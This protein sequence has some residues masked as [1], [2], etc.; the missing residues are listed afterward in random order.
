MGMD[1]AM[2]TM[3]APIDL[4]NLSK[5][6][7]QLNLGYLGISVAILGVLGGVFVYFNIRP[8]QEKLIDQEKAIED[9]K[10]EARELLDKS[11]SQSEKVVEDFKVS[12]EKYVDSILNREH[13]NISLEITKAISETEKGLLEKID[14]VSENKDIKLREIIVSEAVNELGALEK[15]LTAM[16][17]SLEG[18]LGKKTADLDQKI[19]RAKS[20]ISEIQRD[21]KEL[22]VYKF[23][24]EGQMGAIIYSIQLLKQD[25]EDNNSSRIVG[26]LE[27]L[28]KEIEDTTLEAHYVSQIEEQLARI[29]NEPKYKV[30]IGELR[31]KYMSKKV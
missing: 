13:E 16:T 20:S 17:V 29:E 24:K 23:S 11:K 7:A 30:L 14:T 22:K 27:R 8:I 31:S 19:D 6:I 2:T 10:K 15:K 3:I 4:I 21:I 18:T 5:D 28:S 12:F 26:S 1:I 25:I 9:L